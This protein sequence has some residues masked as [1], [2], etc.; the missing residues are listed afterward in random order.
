MTWEWNI[1][2]SVRE[3]KLPN[4]WNMEGNFRKWSCGM[5]ILDLNFAIFGFCRFY[6]DFSLKIGKKT[7]LI[8]TNKFFWTPF[9][10]E[11]SLKSWKIWNC[12]KLIKTGWNLAKKITQKK[13]I[14]IAPHPS[15]TCYKITS[16]TLEHQIHS[17]RI[18]ISNSKKISQHKIFISS[19]SIP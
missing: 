10:K 19:I 9:T 15:A 12:H 18:R 8:A 1:W 2:T 13:N 5:K 17:L 14:Q 4:C 7:D 11:S 16:N 6:L 3:K